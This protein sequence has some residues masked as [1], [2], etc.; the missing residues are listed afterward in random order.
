M[1][2]TDASQVLPAKQFDTQNAFEI[3]GHGKIMCE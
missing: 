2:L 3:S 1:R